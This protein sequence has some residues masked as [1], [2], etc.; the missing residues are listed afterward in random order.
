MKTTSHYYIGIDLHKRFSQV[1]VLDQD[2]T[3]VWKGRI[4]GNDPQGFESLVHSL[5]GPCSAVFEAQMNW[6]VKGV[7]ARQRG[8]SK[9]SVKGVS[10]RGQSKGSVKGV[11][12]ERHWIK[13]VFGLK[14]DGKPAGVR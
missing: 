14:G 13:L 12:P 8:Q 5:G 7:R 3:T 2:G 9:G 1:H 10:Q 6:H 4:D 11:S